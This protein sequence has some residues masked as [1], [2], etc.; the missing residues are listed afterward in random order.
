[1]FFLKP[2]KTVIRIASFDIGKKN[3]AQYVDDSDVSNL[4]KLEKKYEFL[5]KKLKRKFSGP[6]N[7]EIES[8]LN[9]IYLNSHRVQTGVY[10]LRNDKFSDTLDLKTRIN[11][12]SHLELYSSLW[13]TCDIFIIEQ[14]YFKT[15]NSSK[16]GKSKKG[17]GTEAN[18]DAIKIAESTLMWFL[19]AYPFKEVMYFG[20]QN[21]TQILGASGKMNKIE[22][23][24]WAENKCREIYQ[25]RKDYGMVE[26]FK[27]NDMIFRKRLNTEKIIEKYIN[28]Y[29]SN[30]CSK[31]CVELSEKI[32]RSRQKLDDIGDAC[33]QCQAFKFRYMVAM[34]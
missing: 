14:Q 23:K 21:K 29:P 8:I 9:E 1:M 28:M 16:K 25:L 30:K 10:D 11:L 32:V 20:S 13:D 6:M 12:L 34:F 22:R 5:P 33:V 4:Q 19:N 24:K 18:V 7:S 17:A 15:W 31:D 27:L 2:D 26:I 3:F